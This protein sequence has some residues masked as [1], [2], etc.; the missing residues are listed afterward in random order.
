MAKHDKRRQGL[1]RDVQLQTE[2]SKSV[3]YEA[4][5]MIYSGDTFIQ[6]THTSINPHK[7]D[8]SLNRGK[9]SGNIWLRVN[10]EGKSKEFCIFEEDSQNSHKMCSEIVAVNGNSD[11]DMKEGEQ[12]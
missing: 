5:E 4:Y 7:F 9:M 10:Y 8:L 11:I 6:S 1:T 12:M 3:L 2:Y